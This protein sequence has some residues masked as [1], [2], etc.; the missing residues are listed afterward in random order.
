MT[1]TAR[2]EQLLEAI[3]QQGYWTEEQVEEIHEMTREANYLPEGT[4][5]WMQEDGVPRAYDRPRKAA[6]IAHTYDLPT[7]DDMVKDL[8][9]DT[10]PPRPVEPA[11]LTAAGKTELAAELAR[12]QSKMVTWPPIDP[13]QE[14]RIKTLEATVTDLFR[15]LKALE[16]RVIDPSV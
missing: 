15:R 9:L 1:K 14:E 16:E 12:R 7:E 5:D 2:V 10:P 3:R 6:P 4:E 13:A 8:K 11:E